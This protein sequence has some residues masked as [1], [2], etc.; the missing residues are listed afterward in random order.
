VHEA[1][2][3]V[4]LRNRLVRDSLAAEYSGAI[5]FIEGT[6]PPTRGFALPDTRPAQPLPAPAAAAMAAGAPSRPPRTA[7]TH[8]VAGHARP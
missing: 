6:A 8:D 5:R 2:P 4:R 1:A 3:R 7:S